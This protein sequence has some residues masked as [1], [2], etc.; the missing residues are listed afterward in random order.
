MLD[1][2]VFYLIGI[3]QDVG[4]WEEGVA[5]AGLIRFEVALGR[6]WSPRRRSAVGFSVLKIKG[7]P[8]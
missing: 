6:R 8:F 7:V 3:K 2:D 1:C 4:G 5:A